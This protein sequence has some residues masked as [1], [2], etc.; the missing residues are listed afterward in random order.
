ART[1]ELVREL[2]VV[3]D[4]AVLDDDDGAVLVRDRLVAG[5]E[6]DDR[7]AA[8]GEPDRAVDEHSVRIGA[9]VRERRA[10]RSEPLGIRGPAVRGC[11]ADPAHARLLYAGARPLEAEVRHSLVTVPRLGT[12]R[13]A[14]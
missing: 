2:F 3:V 7:Q 4:L 10:H 11:P 14:A 5:V 13:R 8:G 6:V 9:A 1:H 12:R